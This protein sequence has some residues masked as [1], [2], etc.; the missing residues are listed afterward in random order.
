[1]AYQREQLE[2]ESYL[3]IVRQK[4][5]AHGTDGQVFTI[6]NGELIWGDISQGGGSSVFST[7]NNI[8]S[9]NPGDLK[10]DNFVFY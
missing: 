7:E 3:E 4:L 1:M 6:Q 9:N 8:T 5:L 2:V 10:T